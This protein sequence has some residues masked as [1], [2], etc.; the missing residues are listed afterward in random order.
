MNIGESFL[1]IIQRDTEI[2]N[3]I[4]ENNQDFEDE[5]DDQNQKLT[6]QYRSTLSPVD[7]VYLQHIFQDVSIKLSI[8]QNPGR[9]QYS[10][11]RWK[12]LIDDFSDR[13]LLL[14]DIFFKSRLSFQ[15]LARTIKKD[16]KE[17]DIE[18]RCMMCVAVYLK[19]HGWCPGVVGKLINILVE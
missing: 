15:K 5:E 2:Q 16:K 17:C 11:L 10:F 14:D 12:R 9:F 18:W 13:K 8:I 7:V 3:R 1:Q 6:Y 4:N 19:I